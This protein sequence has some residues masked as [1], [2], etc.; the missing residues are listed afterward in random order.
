[1][2]EFKPK[3]LITHKELDKAVDVRPKVDGQAVPLHELVI[4]V[5]HSKYERP[6]ETGS[7]SWVA[8]TWDDPETWRRRLRGNIVPVWSVNVGEW[9][10]N[11]LSKGI[12]PRKP[13]NVSKENWV[14][15]VW[16]GNL[17]VL[18]VPQLKL[19]QEQKREIKKVLYSQ[20]NHNGTY[21]LYEAEEKYK[22]NKEKIDKEKRMEQ[23]QEEAR[24]LTSKI[25][26][27]LMD[28]EGDVYSELDLYGYD[29]A[30]L[31]FII[32]VDDLTIDELRLVAENAENLSKKLKG[33]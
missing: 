28:I 23:M 15:A 2:S 14:E 8:N 33:D 12:M 29:T 9:L 18:P 5:Y 30:S 4:F 1:M 20:I 26:G 24:K 3:R 10:E 21:A 19:T 27:V 6:L 32:N 25:E 16:T 13:N 22:E 11:I 31:D 7:S 17:D